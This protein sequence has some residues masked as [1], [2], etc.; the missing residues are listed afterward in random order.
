VRTRHGG[1]QGVIGT[2]GQI[3]AARRARTRSQGR[4]G[5]ARRTRACA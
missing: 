2:K 5:G 1:F 4:R 3:S